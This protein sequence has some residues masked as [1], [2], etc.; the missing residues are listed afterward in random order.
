MLGNQQSKEIPKAIAACRQHQTD[1]DSLADIFQTLGDSCGQYAQ[2][3]D[4]AHHQ[5]LDELKELAAEALIGEIFFAALAPVTAGLS[6][7][8]GNTALGIRIGIKARRIATI[9]G[10][11]ATRA[12]EITTKLVKPLVERIRPLLQKIQK[13]VNE[14]KATVWRRKAPGG[15]G[16]QEAMGDLADGAVLSSANADQQLFDQ[17]FPEL[18]EVN[19]MFKSGEWGFQNNCQSCVVAVEQRLAGHEVT[20]VQRPNPL[21]NGGIDFT[22]PDG[23][24]NAVGNGKTFQPISGYTEIEAQLLADGP[25]SRAVIHGMRGP[26]ANGLP[27]A[28]HVFNVVNRDGK[29][30]YV[31]GQTG[32]W[33]NLENYANFELLRT[34]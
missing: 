29:I 7:A 6:E 19:P 30:F 10:E 4:D 18:T 24:L 33:A 14:A 8:A 28:G 5:I 12:A 11:L 17:L 1:L 15:P 13:W 34:N 21:T 25:G 2:H 32:G 9:I 20:A 3:L 16:A 26:D 27:Q 23:V 22:W 31:D